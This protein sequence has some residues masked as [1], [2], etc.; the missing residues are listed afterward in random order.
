M[1]VENNLMTI[2]SSS[3]AQSG[4]TYLAVTTG[5]NLYIVKQT[6]QRSWDAFNIDFYAAA[7]HLEHIHGNR[8]TILG[9]LGKKVDIHEIHV[10]INKTQIRKAIMEFQAYGTIGRQDFN[11]TKGI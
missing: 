5:K 6:G 9:E 11:I 8:G 1:L 2:S 10:C 3:T 7:L 4:R